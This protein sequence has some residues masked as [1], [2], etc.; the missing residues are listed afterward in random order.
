[1]HERCDVRSGAAGRERADM[2]LGAGLYIEENTQEI[3]GR[4]HGAV[5]EQL[6]FSE[7]TLQLCAPILLRDLARA[8]RSDERP[9]APWR[10]AVLLVLSQPEGGV[11]GLV[12]EFALLRRA[13]WDTLAARNRPITFDERSAIDLYLDEAAAYA[14]ERWASLV[15]AGNPPI[16]SDTVLRPPQPKRTVR[17]DRPPPLPRREAPPPLP[18]R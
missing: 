9:E 6:G 13:I 17:K 1:M 18:D 5:R 8:M 10:R 14:C 16:E 3:L 11:R 12:R 7:A 4:Y 15:R 2:V